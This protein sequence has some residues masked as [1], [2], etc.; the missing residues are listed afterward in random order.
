MT[1][2]NIIQA[3]KKMIDKKDLSEN[4][5]SDVMQAVMQGEV[6]SSQLGGFLVGLA[7]KGEAV[8][9]IIAAVKI[10][11][12]L[13][14]SVKLKSKK[15]LVDTCGTGGDGAGIFNVSTASVFVAA[16]A[17]AVVAKHGNRSISSKSGSADV[18]EVAGANLEICAKDVAK[19]IEKIGVGFM[20][21]P[22]YHGAMKYAASVRRELK[23]RSIFNILGPLTNPAGAPNQVLGVYHKKL[24][25]PI[26]ETLKALGA[27]HVF[28]LHSEDGLDEISIAAPTHIA[29][30]KNNHIYYYT[31]KPEDFNLRRSSLDEI[32]V[33]SAHESLLLMQNAFD[34]KASVAKD[35]IALNAGAAIYVAG[36]AKNLNEG[37]LQAI[38]ILE[39]GKAQQKLRDFIDNSTKQT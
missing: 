20:F 6:L 28:V 4:E 23:V 9:E 14:T 26:C 33:N 5:M 25:T 11:R 18:L 16:S 3:I 2:M 10:M 29:E 7:A 35:I 22:N 36:K 19:S 13:A 31:I 34:G 32:K 15:Y 17:G 38:S 12:K 1:K 27:R 24:L 21:A 37:V 39:S 30:L 8:P